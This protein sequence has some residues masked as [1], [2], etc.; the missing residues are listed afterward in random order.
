VP[1]LGKKPDVVATK[2]GESV[3]TVRSKRTKL[4]SPTSLVQVQPVAD[5]AGTDAQ[6]GGDLFGGASLAQPQQGGEA[7]VKA[8]V[9]LLAAELFEPLPRQGIQG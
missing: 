4:G 8:C 3:G 5:G 9:L 7:V 1:L 6:E 2:V